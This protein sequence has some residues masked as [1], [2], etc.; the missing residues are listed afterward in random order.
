M[1]FR[2]PPSDIPSLIRARVS[3]DILIG[4][5]RISGEYFR[6]LFG[7]PLQGENWF[8]KSLPLRLLLDGWPT[9]ALINQ[10]IALCRWAKR[11]FDGPK[12]TE[13]MRLAR[14]A[15]AQHESLMKRL[16]VRLPRGGVPMSHLSEALALGLRYAGRRKIARGP[17]E[18]LAGILYDYS[19]ATTYAFYLD[20]T[21]D[22]ATALT[23]ASGFAETISGMRIDP[24]SLRCEPIAYGGGYREFLQRALNGQ[25]LNVE[26]I[27]FA[28]LRVSAKPK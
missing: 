3:S 7:Y 16:E 15:V 26:S 11:L 17:V 24:A 10:P 2:L 14:K 9:R 18:A 19:F 13:M 6:D 28:P 25:E 21:A 12:H 22:S 4:E 27:H 1:P 23:S 5:P 20:L 8:Q